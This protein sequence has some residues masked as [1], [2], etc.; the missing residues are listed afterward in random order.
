MHVGRNNPRNDYKIG[1]VLLEKVSEERDLGVHLSDN[2][3]PSLQCV[4]AAKKAIHVISPYFGGSSLYFC[5]FLRKSPYLE[6]QNFPIYLIHLPIWNFRSPYQTS[7]I[8]F[9]V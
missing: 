8:P 2:L 4:E 6:F 9:F 1:S 3:K 5:P 7:R